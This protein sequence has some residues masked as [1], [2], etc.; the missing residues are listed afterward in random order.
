MV[1]FV[2][3]L[4]RMGPRISVVPNDLGWDLC[5]AAEPKLERAIQDEAT[6][7]VNDTFF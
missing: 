4:K 2:L 1:H 5:R 6:M 7:L 3:E